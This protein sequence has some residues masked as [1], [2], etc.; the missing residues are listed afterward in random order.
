M[1]II[2]SEDLLFSIPVHEKQDIINNQIENILNHNPNAK[3]VLHVNKSFKDFN[4]KLTVYENV[5]INS[6]RFNYTFGKGLLWIHINNFL[7]MVEN[8]VHFKYFIILSSNEMFIKPGLISYINQYKNGLQIVEYNKNNKWHNF[9]KN[10]EHDVEM[11][12]LLNTVGLTTFY[13]GQT[14][15]QFYEHSIFQKI[16][17]IYIQIFGTNEIHSYETEEVISQTIFKSLAL[18][19][20]LTY[21]LPITLQNYC[22]KIDFT[23]DFINKL[24]NDSN[25]IIPD[26]YIKSTLKSPHVGENNKSIFSVKR[27]DRSFN[28]IRIYLSKKGF[29]I[30]YDNMIIGANYYSNNSILRLVDHDIND[31]DIN[32][33]GLGHLWFRKNNIGKYHSFGYYVNIYGNSFIGIIK[34]KIKFNKKI[35]LNGLNRLNGLNDL[36][37]K[38]GLKINYPYEI[39]YNTFLKNKDV[40]IWYDIQIDH[41]IYMNQIDKID[42]NESKLSIKSDLLT[43]IFDDYEKELDLEIKEFQFI[44]KSIVEYKK[45]NLKNMENKNIENKNIENIFIFLC[46]SI[47]ANEY[48]YENIYNMI[49]K[50]LEKKYNIIFINHVF[51][52]NISKNIQFFNPYQIIELDDI[53]NYSSEYMFNKSIYLLNYYLENNYINNYKFSLFFKTN[54]IFEQNIENMNIYMNKINISSIILPYLNKIITNS[55]DFI[56]I[57]NKYLDKIYEILLNKKDDNALKY[58]YYYLKDEIPMNIIYELENEKYI[59]DI[60][61]YVSNIGY[62]LNVNYCKNI[63][64]YNDF[65]KF[66]KT[67]DHEYYF[68]KKITYEPKPFLWFGHFL[69]LNEFKDKL[70]NGLNDEYFIKV[71][72]DIK[73]LKNIVHN[74]DKEY[75][76]KTHNPIKYYSDWLYELNGVIDE[77]KSVEILINIDKIDQYVIFYFDNYLDEIEFYIKNIKILL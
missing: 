31:Y 64:Y 23:K 12:E 21:G 32:D 62:L 28:D 45:N 1:S 70:N 54:Y 71:M 76:I 36:D 6:R 30:D 34:F 49:V 27:V 72:F 2:N 26:K 39:F 13:G 56:L 52:K 69:Y 3:I 29:I 7:E 47:Y 16:A 73:L 59:K 53:M 22:N 20:E 14:E 67:D 77:Y 51:K 58:I 63:Y 10:L 68:Y 9:Q 38:I 46:D 33:C 75:G 48:V 35:M 25:F 42:K 17:D 57:P 61:N 4:E 11:K 65:T 74:E 41:N 50:P 8:G 44:K 66:V 40:N 24:I 37:N 55:D 5:F 18:K 43:F 15:G 60:K 19:M